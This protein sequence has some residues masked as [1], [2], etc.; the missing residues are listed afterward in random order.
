MAYWGGDKSVREKGYL[1][2][3]ILAFVHPVY[4]ILLPALFLLL[5]GLPFPGGAVSINTAALRSK[6]WESLVSLAGPLSNFVLFLILAFLVHPSTGLIDPD[7]DQQPT[8]AVV[9]GTMC[10]LELYCVF[11]NLIPIPP[12]DGYGII[13]PYLDD[14]IRIKM[15]SLGIGG[16]FIIYMMFRFD[17]VREFFWAG[18]DLVLDFLG[19]PFEVSWRAY[20]ITFFGVSE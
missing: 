3:N 20:N 10:I 14:E 11:F 15:R 17:P 16:L 9:M 2:F 6:H 4:S 7:V 19:V 13:E 12:L 5:G 1:H 18:I 8:W